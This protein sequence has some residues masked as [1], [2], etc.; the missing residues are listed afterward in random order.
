MRRINQNWKRLLAMLLLGVLVISAVAV[1]PRAARAF[2][3]FNSGSDYG[4]SSSGSGSSWGS[5]SSDGDSSD[6]IDLTFLWDFIV[7][8]SELFG[9]SPFVVLA[10]LAILYLGFRFGL[11]MLKGGDKPSGTVR[12]D[13]AYQRRPE[14]L[15]TL[16][17]EDPDFDETALLQRVR[18]L[19]EKMQEGWEQ[20]NIDSLR[21]DFMPDTWTR[22]NTQL[23][24]KTAAGDTAHV[25]NIV[26]DDVFLMNYT[27]DA[28]HQKLKIGIT[29]THN[30]WE[31]NREGKSILGTE[32]TRKRFEFVWTMTRPLGSR[33]GTAFLDAT[34]CPNCGAEIDPEAFAECPFCHTP[35]MKISPDW[36]ISE[37]DALSQKTIHA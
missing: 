19:F 31:T 10:V 33:T 24:N 13:A 34:H 8:L 17:E 7:M 22:F 36:V 20:G 1:V 3:D 12:K 35:I 14:T 15:E 21:K 23:Q 27:T 28:E 25:R 2:G 37:I 9:V 32:K 4:G 11:K 26:F 16:R 18:E 30:I 29:V 6:G 5:S